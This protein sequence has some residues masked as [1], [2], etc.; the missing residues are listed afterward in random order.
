MKRGA[1]AGGAVGSVIGGGAAGAFAAGGAAA[2]LV[3]NGGATGGRA[4]GGVGTAGACCFARMAFSTSP[5][6]EMCDRSILVLISSSAR[7]ARE[8]LPDAAASVCALKWTRT[9]SASWSSKELE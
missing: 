7:A 1:A 4:G 9:F 3:S 8:A 5:G 2:G 6:L